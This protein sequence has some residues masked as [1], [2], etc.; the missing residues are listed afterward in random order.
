MKDDIIVKSNQAVIIV[1]LTTEGVDSSQELMK[2]IW[3]DHNEGSKIR[4]KLAQ[5]LKCVTLKTKTV[6]DIVKEFPL[7]DYVEEFD[8]VLSNIYK[9]FFTIIRT[10]FLQIFNERR[11]YFVA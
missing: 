6:A 7:Y 10:V 11:N 2:R 8:I 4:R 5:Q 3:K 1:F 9:T